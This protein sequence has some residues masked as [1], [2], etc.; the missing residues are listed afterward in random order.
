MK[1]IPRFGLPSSL[2]SDNATSFNSKV[3]QGVSKTLGITYYPHCAWRSQSS[4]KVEKAR[5]FL[6]SAIKKITQETSSR[7]EET[8]PIACLCTHMTHKEQVSLSPYEVLYER[9][10]MLMTSF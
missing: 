3:T 5:K 7:L 6:R 9:L 10:F 4:G 2:Q 8:L 1:I